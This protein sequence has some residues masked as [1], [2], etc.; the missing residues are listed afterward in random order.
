M[1]LDLNLGDPA[2]WEVRYQ[3]EVNDRVGDLG[4]FDWYCPF[5]DLYPMVKT[6][7]DSTIVHKVLIIGVGRS[8]IIQNLYHEGYRDITAIDISQTI[9]TE[10]QKRY[11]SYPG[12]EFFVMDVKQ[13]YKFADNTFTLVFDKACIDA[14]FCGTD[15]MESS[16]LAFNEIHRVLK[17]EGNFLSVTH[18]PPI[19]RVPYLR[20]VR[21]A[22][23][24]YKIPSNIGESLILY[25]ITKTENKFM[26]DRRIPGAEAAIRSKASRVVSADQNAAKGST[27]RTG[28]NT[29]IITVTASVDKLAELVAESEE[30][31]S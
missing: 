20:L 5:S 16:C 15:Y 27:N 19:A 22:V 18:A 6:L 1:S 23:E 30:V 11:E 9:I 10:M 17:S 26:L 3:K 25:V 31:D 2:Y 28:Q 14:L 7:Y 8:N 13:L 4:L 29:G 21:W 24:M 12:V